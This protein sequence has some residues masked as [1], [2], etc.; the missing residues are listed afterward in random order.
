MF[1]F[2]FCVGFLCFEGAKT[3]LTDFIVL[4]MEKQIIL[5][6]I[7]PY[8]RIFPFCFTVC[9]AMPLY[10]E[11]KNDINLV[12]YSRFM[13]T[14]L[15]SKNIFYPWNTFTWL[16][17]E[18]ISFN[19]NRS[20]WNSYEQCIKIDENL[21][22]LVMTRNVRNWPTGQCEKWNPPTEWMCFLSNSHCWFI[23]RVST[24]TSHLKN[25]NEMCCVCCWCYRSAHA[26]TLWVMH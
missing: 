19:C 14:I 10:I 11:T 22:N 9:P 24:H 17:C 7:V 25:G 8:F 4:E 26:I 1:C 12:C 16:V 13:Q 20:L 2:C 15:F 18:K 3:K 5:K 21:V 23:A 6:S